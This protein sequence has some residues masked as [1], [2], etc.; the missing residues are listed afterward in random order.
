MHLSGAYSCCV[1]AP[2]S[3]SVAFSLR[4]PSLCF[5]SLRHSPC[6]SKPVASAPPAF[7]GSPCG[8]ALLPAK[9]S[10]LAALPMLT[11]CSPL[12]PNDTWPWPPPPPLLSW[13]LRP[14]DGRSPLLSLHTD[15]ITAGG[16]APGL[17]PRRNLCHRPLVRNP[18]SCLLRQNACHTPPAL[19]TL[20]SSPVS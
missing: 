9:P 10:T 2:A 18:P 15:P 13:P 5:T 8:A 11:S 12:V 3:P 14:L 19:L 1:S 7:A 20:I 17:P 6:A 4:R 16:P